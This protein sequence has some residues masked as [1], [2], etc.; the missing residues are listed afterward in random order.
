MN[1]HSCTILQLCQAWSQGT[2]GDSR[3]WGVSRETSPNP[4][5]KTRNEMTWIEHHERAAVCK[6]WH[7]HTL[8]VPCIFKDISSWYFMIFYDLFARYC[9]KV[10]GFDCFCCNIRCLF[11]IFSANGVQ[12]QVFECFRPVSLPFFTI[13][14]IYIIK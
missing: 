6:F 1:R 10:T 12:N 3:A 9:R 11:F 8:C 5:S 7:S 13:S 4:S 14:S 2:C